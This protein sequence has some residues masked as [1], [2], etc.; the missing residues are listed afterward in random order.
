MKVSQVLSKEE[1]AYFSRKSDWRGLGV[2][3]NSWASLLVLFYAAA[4]WTNPLTLALL[5]ILLPGRMLS[6]AVI[7]HDCGHKVLFKSDK[8]NDF[9]GHYLG[10]SLVFTDLNDYASSHRKHHKLAGTDQDPDLTNY[11]HYPV[12]KS[13]LKRKL[14]RDITGQTGYKLLH[15][16][17]KSALAFR[18]PEQRDFAR[19]YVNLLLI[20]IV[21]AVFVSV[22]FSPMIYLIWLG[23]FFTTYMI[24]VRLRQLAEHAAVPD[25]YDLD[26]RL[27][28]R[29]VIARWWEKL[30]LAPNNVNFHIEHHFMASV[31]CYRLEELHQELQKKG[32][33]EDTDIYKGYHSLLKLL[34]RA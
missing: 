28:T 2:V 18:H 21:F 19:T 16:I 13:S 1:I 20:Q 25:L 32:L 23:S 26:P 33:Y 22:V 12:E 4:A 9:F 29:T 3:L 31:P 8:L 34:T 27:N 6:L 17:I 7:A 11:Q 15:F 5:V 10:G 30:F 14:I 24:I